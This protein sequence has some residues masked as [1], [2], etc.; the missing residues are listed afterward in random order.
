[1]GSTRGDPP[2][3]QN[4]KRRF[5]QVLLS[6]T[7]Q[8]Q[9]FVNRGYNAPPEERGINPLLPPCIIGW[10]DDSPAS[11]FSMDSFSKENLSGTL[12]VAE[13]DFERGISDAESTVDLPVLYSVGGGMVSRSPVQPGS[14]IPWNEQA[15]LLRSGKPTSVEISV[16]QWMKGAEM[17]AL[18]VDVRYTTD[19]NTI[20]EYRQRYDNYYDETEVS[21]DL[22]LTFVPGTDPSF[23]STP[24]LIEE[25]SETINGYPVTR[26]TYRIADW[27]AFSPR[28]PN[29]IAGLLVRESEVGS[30]AE[31]RTRSR[32]GRQIIALCSLTARAVPLDEEERRALG[33]PGA[34]IV[35]Q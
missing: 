27:R 23:D 4:F 31:I 26:A 35:W 21:G 30:D 12:V 10:T 6:E 24:F 1:M 29:R 20:M 28:A 32:A 15:V 8:E 22:N 33:T 19:E 17:R 9:A 14:G 18:L 16:P 5:A 3:L 2:N 11:D 34:R 25:V 13:V 7:S